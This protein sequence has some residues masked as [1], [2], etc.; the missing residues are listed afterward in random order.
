[1]RLGPGL[2]LARLAARAAGR[3]ERADERAFAAWAA[4][5]LAIA[6]GEPVVFASDALPRSP[7]GLTAVERARTAA[8]GAAAMA[9]QQEWPTWLAQVREFAADAV[10]SDGAPADGDDAAHHAWLEALTWLFR[11]TRRAGFSLGAPV[12]RAYAAGTTWAV[13]AG[14][15]DGPTGPIGRDPTAVAAIA[16]ALAVARGAVSG[17]VLPVD[18]QLARFYLGTAA[19]SATPFRCDDWTNWAFPATGRAVFRRDDAR[20]VV[21]A[22]SG[23]SFFLGDVAVFTEDQAVP[24][25]LTETRVDVSTGRGVNRGIARFANRTLTLRAER[26]ILEGLGSRSWRFGPQV[27][28]QN[29]PTGPTANLGMR[30]LRLGLDER[31]RWSVEGQQLRGGGELTPNESVRLS[32]EWA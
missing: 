12:E 2:D 21:A 13:I 23:F 4:A 31:L 17:V 10:A 18:P 32:L 24:S 9:W 7:R 20:V 25:P 16:R 11:E 19:P 1:M 26:L 6:N 3:G 15:A 5:W 8:Y 30:Q 27:R 29:T 14:P 28:L 22:A